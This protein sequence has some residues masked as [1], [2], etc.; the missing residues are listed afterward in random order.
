MKKGG[1]V[2]MA[3]RSRSK[4]QDAINELKAETGRRAIFLELDLANLASVKRAAEEFISKEE[5]L[6]V[7]FN[8]GYVS[9]APW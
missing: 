3:S 6:H 4:A 9:L 1:K 7:L 5:H 2:Y 8:S